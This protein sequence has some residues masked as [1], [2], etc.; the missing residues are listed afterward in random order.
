[1]DEQDNSA[2]IAV[3]M[4]LDGALDH[5]Q[6]L[7]TLRARLLP[8]PRFSQ[9]VVEA[10][11]GLAAP[12]W[13]EDPDFRLERHVR[14]LEARYEGVQTL[15]DIVSALASDPLDFS[16]SPWR[17]CIA[18]ST[19]GESALFAQIHHCMGDGSVLLSLLLSLADG[20][21][22][23]G[24]QP[25]AEP[26]R[27][28]SRFSAVAQRALGTAA[29]LVRLLLLPF[30]HTP[31]HRP[32]SGQRRVAWSQGILLADVKQLARA[33]GATVNDVLMATIAA[34]L[35]RYL[36]ERNAPEALRAIVPVDL[37][38]P[39]AL[40]DGASGNWFGLVFASLPTGE[41]DDHQR[42]RLLKLEMDRLKA[43]EEA[44]VTLGLLHV[45]GRVPRPLN[46]LL[47]R[48]FA[49]KASLVVS[50]VPGPRTPLRISG[51]SIRELMFWA[52]HPCGL[53]C[54]ASLLSYAGGVRVGIRSDSAVMPDPARLAEYFD[55][56][57]ARLSLGSAATAAEV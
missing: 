30:E 42:F 4:V 14:R 37:R 17:V 28:G 8:H 6:L 47:N 29:E 53:G 9:R 10:A 31:L 33:R 25:S 54:G 56:E 43:S 46:Q 2:D 23:K 12:R 36:G 16:H 26:K 27:Q 11:S 38:P 44:I 5:E 18:E 1:M 32:L 22:L 35:R 52:P 51:R 19:S 21:D 13:Q 48:V 50:N 7:D 15:Q 39:G 24:K 57:M 3:L 45:L 20:A 49:R 40:P 34:A 41:Q 55:Q